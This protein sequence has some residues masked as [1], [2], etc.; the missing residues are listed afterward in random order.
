MENPVLLTTASVTELQEKAREYQDKTPNVDADVF[1]ACL[2]FAAK[3][4]V[5]RELMERNTTVSSLP[6]KKGKSLYELWALIQATNPSEDK[7]HLPAQV[8][9]AV[10]DLRGR[11][12]AFPVAENWYSQI[13]MR[14]VEDELTVIRK[15]REDITAV[16]D[17]AS[18]DRI[19]KR[20]LYYVYYPTM[21]NACAPDVLSEVYNREKAVDELGWKLLPWIQQSLRAGTQETVDAITNV[22]TGTSPFGKS[23][24]LLKHVSAH[25]DR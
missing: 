17:F 6:P 2:Q 24:D 1:K 5:N 4:K 11:T 8:E 3:K 13:T 7:Y 25:I 22:L 16:R 21:E 20:N 10:W 23:R 14:E 12:C 18:R 19:T 9:T 15:P